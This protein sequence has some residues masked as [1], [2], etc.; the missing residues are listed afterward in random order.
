MILIPRPFPLTTS[1]GGFH[2]FAVAKPP[3]TSPTASTT[4]VYR[5]DTY[6]AQQAEHHKKW[7][8]EQEFMT[9]L[10]KSG[11]TIDKQRVFG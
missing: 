11:V 9:L 3:G 4:Q 2:P 10:R 7:T 5:K 6:I 1:T 8:F